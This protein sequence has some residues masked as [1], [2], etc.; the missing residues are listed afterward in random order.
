MQPAAPAVAAAAAAAWAHFLLLVSLCAL[1][2]AAAGRAATQP[3]TP[4]M[5]LQAFDQLHCG[6]IWVG[7]ARGSSEWVT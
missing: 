4:D 2:H 5:P 3:A 6:L 1:Q 7:R